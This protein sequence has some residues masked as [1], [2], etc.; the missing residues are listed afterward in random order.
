[1]KDFLGNDIA[2]GDYAII[3]TPNYRDFSLSKVIKLTEKR[4]RVVYIYQN[5]Q[6]EHVVSPTSIVKVQKD[7]LAV[8]ML[9]GQVPKF[10]L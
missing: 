10:S 7:D 4:I 1:M 6:H 5:S 2:V 3:M 8:M 9:K